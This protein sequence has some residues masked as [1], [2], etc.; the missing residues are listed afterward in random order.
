MSTTD[1]LPRRGSP[2]DPSPVSLALEPG[3][4]KDVSPHHDRVQPHRN[5]LSKGTKP[6]FVPLVERRNPKSECKK[7]RGGSSNRH[8][9]SV[10]G[11]TCF[12]SKRKA[13]RRRRDRVRSWRRSRFEGSRC[14]P[15]RKETRGSI[16]GRSK[17]AT[18]TCFVRAVRAL[19]RIRSNKAETVR[20]EEARVY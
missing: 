3:R 18:R 7:N 19:V 8:R 5:P 15:G 13:D 12:A 2:P 1:R 14:V 4:P 16:A 20:Q 9:T 6:R 10:F 11:A 17:E